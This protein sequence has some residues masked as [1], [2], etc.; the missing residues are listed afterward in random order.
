MR[1]VDGALDAAE[2]DPPP[3]AK[4]VLDAARSPAG[5]AAAGAAAAAAR[6][7]VA[8]G[9]TA[10]KAAIPVGK[11]ALGATAKAAVGLVVGNQRKKD[12]K[13]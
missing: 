10:L 8:L 9:G 2:A 11:W 4:V 12:E 7:A 1:R 6:G 3:G 13:K 5:A